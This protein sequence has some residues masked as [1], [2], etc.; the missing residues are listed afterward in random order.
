LLVGLLTGVFTLFI[1][2]TNLAGVLSAN[3]RGGDAIDNG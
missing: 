1:V 3:A 2:L